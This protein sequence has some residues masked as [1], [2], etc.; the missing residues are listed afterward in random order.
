MLQSITD[1]P[2]MT[3]S[4]LHLKIQWASLQA[5]GHIRLCIFWARSQFQQTGPSKLLSVFGLI[6]I[7]FLMWW[8]E[9]LCA[10][11]RGREGMACYLGTEESSLFQREMLLDKH[12][13][14]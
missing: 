12:K 5:S 7:L 2:T 8:F 1:G 3:C 10:E 13:L 14:A 9:T 4:L 11:E 6:C